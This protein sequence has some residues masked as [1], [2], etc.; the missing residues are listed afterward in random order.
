[1]NNIGHDKIPI[2]KNDLIVYILLE[3]A[4]RDDYII[5]HEQLKVLS[6]KKY[7]YN[8]NWWARKQ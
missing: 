2:E 5:F 1:M 7:I 6:D 8:F 4:V 3:K